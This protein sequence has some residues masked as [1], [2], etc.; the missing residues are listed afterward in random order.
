M[1]NNSRQYNYELSYIDA[2]LRKTDMRFSSVNVESQSKLSDL[3][4]VPAEIEKSPKIRVITYIEILE[5]SSDLY[6][7][8]AQ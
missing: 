5:I 8:S 1:S 7:A 6:K 2:R 3:C 4:V